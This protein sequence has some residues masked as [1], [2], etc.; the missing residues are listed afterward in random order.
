MDTQIYL[1]NISPWLSQVAHILLLYLL[2]RIK[3]EAHWTIICRCFYEREKKQV[4][5]GYERHKTQTS[6]H[7]YEQDDGN[8]LFV[9]NEA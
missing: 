9:Y 1:L 5:S 7:D 6:R 4:H 3:L 8:P 2:G